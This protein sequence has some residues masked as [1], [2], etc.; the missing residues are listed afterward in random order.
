M[1]HKRKRS[2]RIRSLATV[3]IAISLTAVSLYGIIRII[4]YYQT[5][6][7]SDGFLVGGGNEATKVWVTDTG[8]LMVTF[9][10]NLVLDKTYLKAERI[11][12]KTVLRRILELLGL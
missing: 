12:D 1:S 8:M 7:L 4:A 10:K 6:M 3:A 5:P 11:G 2:T 9:E